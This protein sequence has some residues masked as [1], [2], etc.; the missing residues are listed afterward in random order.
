MA[1][2]GTNAW[3]LGVGIPNPPAI[4]ATVAAATVARP[5][6]LKHLTGLYVLLACLAALPFLSRRRLGLLLSVK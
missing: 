1:V 4:T 6:L 2:P 3:V 5:M